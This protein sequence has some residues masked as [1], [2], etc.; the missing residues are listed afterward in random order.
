MLLE[1]E[2]R[3]HEFVSLSAFQATLGVHALS[4]GRLAV[5]SKVA[6]GILSAVHPMQLAWE[7][8]RVVHTWLWITRGRPAKWWALS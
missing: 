5:D 3:W 1:V 7:L 4:M 6:M 8:H 2:F